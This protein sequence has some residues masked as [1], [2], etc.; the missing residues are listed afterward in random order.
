MKLIKFLSSLFKRKKAV[1]EP[2]VVSQ[3]KVQEPVKVYEQPTIPEP[4][5]KTD[6]VYCVV[7]SNANTTTVVPQGT[8][9][10]TGEVKP[11]KK[12]YYKKKPKVVVPQVDVSLDV[13]VNKPNRTKRQ[14]NEDDNRRNSFKSRTKR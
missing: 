7:P 3:P 1:V 11:K 5:K 8:A 12:R 13:K 6:E 4:V 10:V 14:D 2:I 9:V